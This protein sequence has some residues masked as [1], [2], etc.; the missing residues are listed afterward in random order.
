MSLGSLRADNLIVVA[1]GFVRVTLEPF[2]DVS[3]EFGLEKLKNMML[4]S[5]FTSAPVRIFLLSTNTFMQSKCPM[6]KLRRA[7]R[8]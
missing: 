1:D 8:R 6:L 5:S 7:V 2:G 4:T 3:Q